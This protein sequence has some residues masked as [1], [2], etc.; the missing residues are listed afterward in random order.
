MT[1]KMKRRDFI[2]LLGGATMAW[3]LAAGA[4]HPRKLPTI[5][6]LGSGAPATHGRWITA[7]VE[8]L[9]EI[10]LVEGRDVAIEYRWAEGRLD[11]VIE[12]ARDLVRRK[13]DVIVTAGTP[14]TATIKRLTDIIP[15]VFVGAADPVGAGL[16]ASLARPGG[17]ITGFS[18]QARDSAGKRVEL[19][20]DLLPV[21]RRLAF[22]ANAD[23]VAEM[24]EMRDAQAAASD[25]GLE[26]FAPEVRRAQD[27]APAFAALK[28]R[29]DALYVLFGSLA[30]TNQS[31]INTLALRT[32][33]PTMHG[34]RELVH[35]GGLMS[36]GA[37]NVDLYRRAANV[38][39]KILH[40]TKP[41]DIPVEQPTKFELV[42]NLKT[43]RALGL[44]VPPALLARADEVIE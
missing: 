37:D 22:L 39:A 34:A 8:R 42:I 4:Q 2:T 3:P 16:V 29:A 19:L 25:L 36:Y 27:I 13:V 21:L 31:E 30:I 35:T 9:G 14:F 7:L 23:N 28:G 11:R 1:A 40:G 26:V 18:N 24:L 15:V 12:L 33:M 44:E 41:S 5:G 38:V 32:L 20:R 17:N 43:A 6:Y 10:G